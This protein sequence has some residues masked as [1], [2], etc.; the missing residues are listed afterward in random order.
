MTVSTETP[1]R[2]TRK[3]SFSRGKRW[4]SV[5]NLVA[6]VF[7]SLYILTVGNLI[8]Y[9]HPYRI[10]LTAEQLHTL[11][12]ETKKRLDLVE[13][14]ILVVI[15]Q[16]FRHDARVHR[17]V[18]QRARSLLNQY[19]AY[20][21]KIRVEA[22]LN[23]QRQDDSLRWDEIRKKYHLTQSQL[24]NF[25]FIDAVDETLW[26]VVSL[27]D[28]ATFDRQKIIRFDGERAFTEALTRLRLRDRQKLY[29]LRDSGEPSIT[30]SGRGGVSRLKEELEANGYMVKELSLLQAKAVPPDCDL[31]VVVNSAD[32]L[33]KAEQRKLHDYLLGG[34]RMWVSLGAETQGIE[35]LLDEWGVVASA[36]QAYQKVQFGGG[37][38]AQWTNNVYS[39][40][41]TKG[42]PITDA[43]SPTAFQVVGSRVRPLDI[44][45]KDDL[46]AASIMITKEVSGELWVDEN[47]NGRLDDGE[48]R[49]AVSW[50]VAV[51][52]KRPD[53]P[54]P[55]YVHLPTRIAVFGDGLP[56]TNFW[57]DQSS[58]RDL[59]LNTVRWLVGDESEIGTSG[60][61]WVERRLKWS[62]RIESFLFWVAIFLF[63]GIVMSFGTF[64][65]FLRRS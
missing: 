27:E 35:R 55:G 6:L 57:F 40:S 34:G 32:A 62:P 10:D 33:E 45:L 42:H 38:R 7:L 49:K 1:R 13:D 28:L 41:P 4:V 48:R 61:E 65:Y 30:D 22:E 20:Q 56:W 59:A 25:I 44:T 12:G 29:F 36:G 24:N 53:R 5:A 14:D 18:F 16:L 23:L 46:Y 64:V 21:P 19:I 15:P 31:L 26:Q 2:Q 60:E 52:R 11:S 8:V 17:Q 9:R 51:Q 58:H 3:V 39:R 63:P 47:S 54:Q 43:F 37:M 50:G